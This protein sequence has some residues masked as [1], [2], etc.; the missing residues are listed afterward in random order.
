MQNGMRAL[1]DVLPNA[2]HVT[3]PGQTHM[4]K[5]AALA[6]E[7]VTFFSLAPAAP[8]AKELAFTR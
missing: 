1:A 6:P 3:L 8:R 5:D 4:V 2:Q 7:L